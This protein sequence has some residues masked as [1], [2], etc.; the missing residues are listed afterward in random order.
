MQGCCLYFWFLLFP[1]PSV[2]VSRPSVPV[3]RPSVP[4]WSECRE[5]TLADFVST[6]YV[7]KVYD[8]DTITIASPMAH[9]PSNTLYR[10]SVRLSGIDAPE[11]KGKGVTEEEKKA[12]M[13]VQQYLSDLVLGKQVRLHNVNNEKYG[14]ILAEVYTEENPHESVNQQLL[15]AGLVVVYTGGTKQPFQTLTKK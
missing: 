12:A 13:H 11:R 7:I 8:G 2:P 9:D 4:T 15:R 3:S 1:R 10:C 14:R 5:F 6:G